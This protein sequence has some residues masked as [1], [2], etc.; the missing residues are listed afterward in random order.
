[1]MLQVLPG[2]IAV[3]RFDADAPLPAWAASGRL[4]SVTRTPEE[5]SVVCAADAVPPRV[6]AERG[7]RALRVAGRLDFAMT[8]VIASIAAP[9]ADAGVSLFALSTYDT[10]YVLVRDASL[11]AAIA[12]LTAAGHEIDRR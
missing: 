12:A 1:M 6:A 10:D 4:S 3:A 11:A 7:W 9:L 5:L 2:E 8:G